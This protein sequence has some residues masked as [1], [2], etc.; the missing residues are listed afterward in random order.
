METEWKRV[1]KIKKMCIFPLK[2]GRRVEVNQALCTKQGLM[3]VDQGD[4]S[5]CLRDRSFVVYNGQSL[6]Y[7]TA[8][9]Y[10]KMVLIQV[11]RCCLG[12]IP[13]VLFD[14]PG[15]TTLF[16]T[17]PEDE[18]EQKNVRIIQ[19]KESI[20]ILDCGDEA[21]AWFSSYL[22]G[23]PSPFGFRLGY[24]NGS[25]KRTEVK[26]CYSYLIQH[27]DRGLTTESTGLNA[28]LCALH[29]I[30]ASSVQDITKRTGI[31]EIN[32]DSFRPNLVVEDQF[33][34]AFAEDN[35][36]YIRIGEVILKSVLECTRCIMTCIDME[37]GIRRRDRE[38]L[39]T[40]ERYRMSTG[41]VRAS[42]MGIY[43][44]VAKTGN[45]SLGDTV[46]IS[47]NLETRKHKCLM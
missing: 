10:P 20:S 29:L 24:N 36:E 19:C 21:A 45:I 16:L 46:Y 27:N 37:T 35:W 41:P 5:P 13:F 9:H 44:E 30:S 47:N 28:D 32:E 3:D 42:V 8:R 4:G 39:K 43:L 40:M 17:I 12:A 15:M 14:A 23:E 7:K 11:R 25:H 6:E 31:P 18:P 1:G 34:E 38:P 33:L 2:S 26:E 22:L